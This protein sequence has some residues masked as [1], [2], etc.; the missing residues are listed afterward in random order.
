MPR[1]STL[2]RIADVAAVAALSA[3]VSVSLQATTPE[4]PPGQGTPRPACVADPM[5]DTAPVLCGAAR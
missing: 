2:L 3:F 1:R 4:D 5:S